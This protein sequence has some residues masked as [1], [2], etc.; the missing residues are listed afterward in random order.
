MMPGGSMPPP[1]GA[2]GGGGAPPPPPPPM[3]SG[4]YPGAQRLVEQFESL[5]IGGGG[6]P[7]G[8]GQQQHAADGDPSAWPRPC[9]PD[10]ARALNPPVPAF[11]PGNC[12]PDNMSATCWALPASAALRARWHLPLGIVVQP[13]AD[14]AKGRPVPVIP[15]ASHGIVRCRR[16]RTYMNPFVQWADGGRRFRCNVCGM[17]NDVPVEYF[18]SLDQQGRRRDADERPELSRGTVE[19]V[20]PAEYMVRPPMPPVFFFA[21]D[22]S[23]PAV[24]A[25]LVGAAAQ[26]IRACLDGLPGDDRTLVG[27]LTFDTS[28]HFYSLRPALSAPQ[29]MVVAEID[30]PF[31]PLP[32]DLLVNLRDSRA[33][34][35]QLLESLSGEMFS[36][37]AA[38]GGASSSRR[39]PEPGSATG[40]ALQAAFM[41]MSHVG[42]KLLLFQGSP[43]SLGAGKVKPGR[44]NPS[45]YGTDREPSLR[46]PDDPFFKRFA[47]EASRYQITL[48]VF[49]CAAAPQDLASL[50]A[51]PRF[52]C[53]G[54]KHFPGFVAARDAPRLAAEVRRNLTRPTAWEAVMRVRCSKGLRVSSFH[55][56]FFNRST[57]LLALPTCDPDKGFAVQ[58]AH[59]EAVVP[60]P[61]AYVQCALL[62]TSSNGERRIRVH[63]M[64]LPVTNDLSEMYRAA[65][66]SATLSLLAKI[67]VERALTSRLDETR[68]ALEGRVA[69]CLREYRL[70]HAAAARNPQ[71]LV[72]PSSLRLLPALALGLLKHAALRGGREVAADERAAAAHALMEAP[73]HETVRQAYPDVYALHDSGAAWGTP[74]GGGGAGGKGQGQQNQAQANG[75]GVAASAPSLCGVV[76]P[77]T[78][79]ASAAYL[80]ERGLY[81]I[82]N[83][84]LL[85]LWVGRAADSRQVGELLG[86][87]AAS[88]QADVS[89]VPVEP[90]RAGQ[91]LSRRLC[92]LLGALRQSRGAHPPC[93]ALRQ[94]TP[95]EAVVAPSLVEDRAP[96][97]MAYGDWLQQLQRAVMTSGGGAGPGFGY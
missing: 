8:P 60:G 27:F 20:A 35:D 85:V 1:P 87:E 15:L 10:R 44:D 47:A 72:F 31:L 56:H 89:A 49:A 97:A 95:F 3:A 9:G 32:E 38:G 45:L 12:H 4:A 67:G 69:A 91:A 50:A 18:S 37:A 80:S 17:A 61:V 62:Y 79:P 7:A 70:L 81:L 88:G 93:F 68:R 34:V 71:A 94:G 77:P 52:T 39:A 63:S 46:A 54:V 74:D 23:A 2:L 6:P 66:A 57:D 13:M 30:D 83:G 16:C 75:N 84:L 65:D 11:D 82:D 26:A 86:A 48:D 96:G 22:V 19:W 14:E 78:V 90:E 92:A 58:V 25:G 43:P 29:M 42:G 51:V 41:A 59:E 36:P 28:L 73:Q 40:P 53:G 55:G 21:I 76:L 33:L 24:A 5:Q 64:A